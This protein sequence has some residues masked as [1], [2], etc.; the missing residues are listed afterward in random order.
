MVTIRAAAKLLRTL[1]TADPAPPPPSTLL[2]DW[3]AT[4]VRKRHRH[5][6]LAIAGTTLLPVV[7]PAREIKTLVPRLTAGLVE[8]LRSLEVPAADIACEIAAMAEWRIAKTDDRST[9]GVLMNLAQQ[10]EFYIEDVPDL[11]EL[12][13]SLKLADT[14][15]TAR[16]L[17]PVPATCELFGVERPAYW[18]RSH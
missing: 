16:D 18:R 3:Y 5:V 4:I 7:V 2:G 15:I 9:V 6:V 10:L 14:P 12:T 11:D 1:G 17:I 8:V 13:L